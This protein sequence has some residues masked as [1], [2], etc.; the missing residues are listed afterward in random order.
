MHDTNL[1]LLTILMLGGT[2]ATAV[3]LAPDMLM[4]LVKR[5]KMRVAYIEA[6]R[7]AAA[8]EYASG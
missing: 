8:L 6:G 2:T 4:W 3:W 5:L 1:F 7:K